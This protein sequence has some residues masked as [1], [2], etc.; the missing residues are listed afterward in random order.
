M[1]LGEGSRTGRA[2]SVSVGAHGTERQI[3]HVA[4]A[5]RGTDAVNF[6]QAKRLSNQAAVRSLSE[7]NAYADRRIG[8]LRQDVYA[9]IATVMATSGLPVASSPGKSMVAVA[10]ALYE[11]Q[12]ALAVGLTARSRGGKWTYSATGAGTAQGDFGLTVGLGYHW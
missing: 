4:E 2:N 11:G 5:A 1:A 12:P 7:A 6:R 10:T 8:S 3:S 9:G